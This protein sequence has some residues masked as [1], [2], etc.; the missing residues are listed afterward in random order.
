M[1][2]Y[3][4][5]NEFDIKKAYV[6]IPASFHQY[7]IHGKSS[8]KLVPMQEIII[9]KEDDFFQ[10]SHLLEVGN[11]FNFVNVPYL[12]SIAFQEE[13]NLWYHQTIIIDGFCPYYNEGIYFLFTDQDHP[14]GRR[15]YFHPSWKRGLCPGRPFTWRCTRRTWRRDWNDDRRPLRSGLHHLRAKDFY[16]KVLHRSDHWNYCASLWQDHQDQ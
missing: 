1:S 3:Q 4:L 5:Q 7:T 2:D 8:R 9:D 12:Y 13:N 11:Q 14:A 15:C 10:I 16:L 6:Q